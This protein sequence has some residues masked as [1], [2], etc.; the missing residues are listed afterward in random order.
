[1]GAVNAM[2]AHESPSCLHGPATERLARLDSKDSI[3]IT[4]RELPARQRHKVPWDGRLPA[5]VHVLGSS[6]VPEPCRFD[7]AGEVEAHAVRAAG[8]RVELAR[9]GEP[10]RLPERVQDVPVRGRVERGAGG[11]VGGEVLGGIGELGQA[12]LARRRGRARCALRHV[13]REPVQD[14][15]VV[16]VIRRGGVWVD[17]HDHVL[18][19]IAGDGWVLGRVQGQGGL[20]LC[21]CG[22]CQPWS[23]PR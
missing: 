12:R 2:I 16:W 17:H 8:K 10:L 18:A 14:E 7:K 11:P 3:P 5:D 21:Y 6:R 1:M 9:H 19:V 22:A 15:A 4:P 13:G 23:C 20:V